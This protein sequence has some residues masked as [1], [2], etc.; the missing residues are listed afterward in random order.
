MEKNN[1]KIKKNLIKKM[2]IKR[3]LW[4][5][6]KSIG[7]SQFCAWTINTAGVLIVNTI[8]WWGVN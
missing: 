6:K 2:A 5:D 1:K 4:C 3:V 7:Y 8:Q